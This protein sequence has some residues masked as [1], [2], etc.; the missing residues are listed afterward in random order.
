MCDQGE[1]S[2]E[3]LSRGDQSAGDRPPG[4]A[5]D[6]PSGVEALAV[7]AFNL[8]STRLVVVA[9]S[10]VVIVFGMKYA[11]SIVT[12]ALLALVITIGISPLLSWQMRRGVPR[13]VAL[14]FT[15]VVTAVV[16]SAVLFLLMTS[17]ARF[18]KSLPNYSDEL[19]P[20]WDAIQSGLARV[21]ID[22]SDLTSLKNIDPG[23]IVSVGT[24]LASGVIDTISTL[25]VMALTV[26]FMLMEAGTFSRKLQQ[27]VAGAALQRIDE[28]TADMR[29]FIKVTAIMGAAVAVLQTV[30]LLALGVPSALLW[31]LLSFFFSFIP[32]IGFVAAM[33]PPI[34]M[35]LV[36]GGW[37]VALAVLV[38]YLVINTVSDNLIKP[39]VVGAQTDL[40]PLV[41][42]LSVM[43]W[44][45]VLGPVGSLLAVP[46]TLLG[47]RLI[48]EAYD[49]WQ[50]LS[51]ALGEPPRESPP[52]RQRRQRLRVFGRRR[53]GEKK[54]TS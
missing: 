23:K 54:R 33:I 39:K 20:Y 8:P 22:T 17:M 12:P 36:S 18:I 32:F 26:L 43:L 11:A 47:K 46:V 6:E 29:S 25:S 1:V 50:W 30:M 7:G 42:F 27:G 31:G 38:G 15:L 5:D 13:G 4:V 3:A 34:L 24:G 28:L 45:W 2:A 44:G 53:E 49:E 16:G 41:V 48:L 10:V 35:G 14:F 40:S 19:R 9:A 21:G 37:P 52:T 51:L